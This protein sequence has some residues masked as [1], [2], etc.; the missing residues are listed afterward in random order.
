M[1]GRVKGSEGLP[2]LLQAA[3]GCSGLLWG[4]AP[5]LMGKMI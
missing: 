2:R 3:P 1:P 5:H 4:S